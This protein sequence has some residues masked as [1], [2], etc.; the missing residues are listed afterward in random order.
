M[1]HAS[2]VIPAGRVGRSSPSRGWGSGNRMTFG[3]G[4][5]RVRLFRRFDTR[6]AGRYTLTTVTDS[7][8]RSALLRWIV[9]RASERYSKH[10]RVV[11][12]S[13][14][15]SRDTSGFLTVEQFSKGLGTVEVIIAVLI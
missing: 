13:Y 12:I 15:L 10:A 4:A 14:T 6:T 11:R 8:L 3:Q 2:S 5:P 1:G 9:S 7:A